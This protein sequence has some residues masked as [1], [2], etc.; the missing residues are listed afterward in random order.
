MTLRNRIDRG[1]GWVQ[2][3]IANPLHKGSIPST[4]SIF[5]PM[6]N[7]RW[8]SSGHRFQLGSVIGKWMSGMKGPFITGII[9]HNWPSRDRPHFEEMDAAKAR[10]LML[11]KHH[12]MAAAINDAENMR[13]KL[14]ETSI[15]LSRIK[16][17][18]G[19]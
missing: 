2:A 15:E 19:L 18:K 17:M 5:R 6:Y 9:G 3:R 7:Q 11:E 1:F 10:K 12:A 8:M 14:R 13:E 16:R 4:V